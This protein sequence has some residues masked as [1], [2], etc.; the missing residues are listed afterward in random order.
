[1]PGKASVLAT[2]P[3]LLPKKYAYVF[4]SCLIDLMFLDLDLYAGKK[5]KMSLIGLGSVLIVKNCDLGV[6][7]ANTSIPRS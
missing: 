5:V 7:N 4:C 6:E 2:V 3:S 1:M